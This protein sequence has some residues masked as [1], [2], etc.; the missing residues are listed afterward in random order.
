MNIAIYGAGTFGEY[1]WNQIRSSKNSKII[2]SVFIDKNYQ[3]YKDNQNGIIV[4][5]INEFFSIYEKTV[6]CVLIAALSLIHRQEMILSL[7]KRGYENVYVIPTEVLKGELPILGKDGKFI[8]YIHSFNYS[9]P[10]LPYIEYHVSDYCNLKCKGCGHFSNL[11]TEKKFPKIENFENMLIGLSNKFSNI[12]VFRL[13]G[14][15]PLVNP[16]LPLFIYAVKK[17]FPYSDIRVASN[18]L[19]ISEMKNHVINAIRECNVT[20]DI[21]QYSPTR[22]IIEKIII[23][24][25]KN[26]LKINISKEITKFFKQF[27]VEKK[28]DYEESYQNCVSRTCHLLRDGRLYPCP[29]LKL[30]FEN[31]EFLGMHIE[32]ELVENNSFDIVS[33]EENGWEILK[34]IESPFE[35]CGY[36]NSEPEWF[37]WKISDKEIKRK[38]WLI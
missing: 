35:F 37:D 16:Q 33:G 11:V 32:K 38:D 22:K 5:D 19:L 4:V 8:S 10:V 6:E 24:T 28:N 2:S 7:I 14:G 20:I 3:L 26:R 13:M 36:C 9:M 23:F 30:C 34:K 1:V 25:E 21:S 17:Y 31:K 12:E 15:E 29:G 27:N 18:G